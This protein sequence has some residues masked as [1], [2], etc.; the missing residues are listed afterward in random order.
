MLVD[1]VALSDADIDALLRAPHDL[2][3]VGGTWTYLAAGERARIAEF[4]RRLGDADAGTAL[5]VV[6]DAAADPDT[7]I[8]VDLP[9][10][11]WLHRALAGTWRPTPAE[12]VAEPDLVR[13][14]LRHYQ[15]DGLDWMVWLERNDLGGILADDMGLGKTAMLLALVAH[16]HSGPTL[17]VAPTSVVGNWEREA[18]R[19]TP[20]LRVAIH[21]GRDRRDPSSIDADLVITSYGM[22]RLDPRLADVTWHRVVLDEA[23]AIKNPQTATAKAARA[24]PAHHRVAATGTPVENDLDELWSIMAFACPGLLGPRKAF[25]TRYRPTGDPDIDDAALAHLRA[26]IAAFVMPAH[27]ARSRHRRRAPGASGRARRLPPHA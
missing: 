26:R 20:D 7:E 5:D 18:A 23:Q 15:R 13:L 25:A 12:H 8:T 3:T 27:Q 16:D 19:F 10:G 21:H 4:V 2:V 1:G 9:E 14:P 6:G 17:V 22:L 24:L 11:S